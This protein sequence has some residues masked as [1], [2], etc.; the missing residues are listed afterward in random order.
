MKS[1][2]THCLLGKRIHC[3]KHANYQPSLKYHCRSKKRASLATLEKKIQNTNTDA[4]HIHLLIY[5][6][7]DSD[8]IT[9]WLRA[10]NSHLTASM[11]SHH[12]ANNHPNAEQT[13]R[14]LLH[15]A[16]EPLPNHGHYRQQR[17]LKPPRQISII[18]H[19]H[20]AVSHSTQ[21]IL[22]NPHHP[23]HPYMHQGPGRSHQ[24]GQELYHKN[25]LHKY[26][27]NPS[28]SVSE[29]WPT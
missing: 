6:R 24:L 12:I 9:S 29:T 28:P 13:L 8:P 17:K 2:S 15:E 1:S 5:N 21:T 26:H 3:H 27:H 23:H 18:R 14:H 4:V 10:T 7:W 19:H 11:A 22:S 16:R 25:H 20:L